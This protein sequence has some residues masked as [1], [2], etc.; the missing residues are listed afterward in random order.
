MVLFRSYEES[1]DIC[2]KISRF[3]LLTRREDML[4]RDD[5]IRKVM[6][7]EIAKVTTRHSIQNGLKI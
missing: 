4:T 2:L 1:A 5:S 3:A 6:K 7:V